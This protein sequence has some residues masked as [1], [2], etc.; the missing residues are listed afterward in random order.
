MNEKVI[1]KVYQTNDP[2]GGVQ[3]P[4]RKDRTYL[5]DS[6]ISYELNTYRNWGQTQLDIEPIISGDRNPKEVKATPMQ[7]VVTKSLFN[8]INGV[9]V[10]DKI[11]DIYNAPLLDTPQNRQYLRDKSICTVK[12]LVRA[13]GAGEMGR[14][15]Y[16]YSDFMYCKH[17]GKIPNNYLITLR[18]FPFPCDD[19]INISIPEEYDELQHAPDI[20]RMVTWMGTPGNDMQNIL[21]YNYGVKWREI[22]AKIDEREDQGDAENGPLAKMFNAMS[23]QY[24]KQVAQGTAGSSTLPLMQSMLG[25]WGQK[26]PIGTQ[27]PY[28]NAEWLKQHDQNKN[29]GPLDVISKTTIREDTKNGNGGLNFTQEFS[30]VFDYE[31][32]SY[33]GING[34]AAFLDLLGNILS[35]TYTMGTFWGGSIR[36]YGSHQS[37]IYANL[38]LF[39]PDTNATNFSDRIGGLFK[40]MS[41]MFTWSNIKNAV[42]NMMIGG[43]LNFLGRP[44]KQAFASFLSPAPTG[45]WH[46]TIGNPKNPILSMGNMILEDTEIEHYGPL[47]LDDFPTGIKVTCKLKHGK[48]RDQIK[49]EQMYLGGDHRIYLPA[50]NDIMKLY[51]ECKDYKKSGAEIKYI[52]RNTTTNDKMDSIKAEMNGLVKEDMYKQSLNDK[53]VNKYMKFFGTDN[54]KLIVKSSAEG[55]YGSEMKKKNN[56]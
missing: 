56:N 15:I 5:L 40:A 29:Y 55:S 31:L 12:E 27:G 36:M 13:S 26:A 11:R 25:S 52:N 16:N 10:M 51:D 28:Q 48:P 39:Q 14:A 38:P 22:D 6:Q 53:E 32:R 23:P 54:T 18:R 43:F 17:L 24:Y 9:P 47:G 46:V 3:S 4:I 30:L 49:I 44:H 21:K 2:I 1:N 41:S 34:K 35:T 8:N 37:N 45:E 20:G 19:H 7:V 42:S 33:D 50:G